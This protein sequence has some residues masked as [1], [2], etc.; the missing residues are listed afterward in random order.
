MFLGIYFVKK[1]K[2]QLAKYGGLK[3]WAEQCLK[4]TKVSGESVKNSAKLSWLTN[5][6]DNTVA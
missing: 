3:F 2:T 6:L 1:K 5:L 4:E